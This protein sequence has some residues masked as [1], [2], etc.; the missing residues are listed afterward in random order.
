LSTDQGAPRQ[1]RRLAAGDGFRNPR[2]TIQHRRNPGPLLFVTSAVDGVGQD[3]I[4]A[5]QGRIGG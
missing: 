5:A 3:R 2:N 4:Q 1:R